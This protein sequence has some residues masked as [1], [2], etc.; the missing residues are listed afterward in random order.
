MNR[1]LIC[2]APQALSLQKCGEVWVPMEFPRPR[3]KGVIA[4]KEPWLRDFRNSPDRV[5]QE[6][7]FDASPEWAL[8]YRGQLSRVRFMGGEIV[9]PEEARRSIEANKFWEKHP[10]RTMPEWAV[11]IR[12]TVL[13]VEPRLLAGMTAEQR[14]LWPKCKG[15]WGWRVW[16]V[17]V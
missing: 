5:P 7:I 11:R 10:A 17:A 14:A 12:R 9:P 6:V 8:D 2:K 16:L 1:P 15:E 3:I 4:V 13:T